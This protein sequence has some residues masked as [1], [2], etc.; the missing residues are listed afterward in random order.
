M[1][2]AVHVSAPGA[3]T[4]P[5]RGGLRPSPDGECLSPPCRAAVGEGG[6][7]CSFHEE[8]FARVRQSLAPETSSASERRKAGHKRATRGMKSPRGAKRA[9]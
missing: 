9:A 4:V 3:E 5:S 8:L 6:R 7:F 2:E 1:T